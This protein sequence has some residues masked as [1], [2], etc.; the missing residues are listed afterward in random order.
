[1]QKNYTKSI[2]NKRLTNQS[3]ICRT[4]LFTRVNSLKQNKVYLGIYLDFGLDETLDTCGRVVY[5]YIYIGL[6]G[7]MAT[8]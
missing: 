1:L 5:Q 6:H 2:V 8:L 4:T 3:Y 7:Y